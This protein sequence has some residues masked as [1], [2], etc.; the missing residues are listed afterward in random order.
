[1][2]KLKRTILFAALLLTFSGILS[3]EL[4]AQGPGF[5]EGVEDTPIDGGVTLIAATAVGYGIKKLRDK[6]RKF[7]DNND[8]T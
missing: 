5:D 2:N 8:V 7:D 3:T 1:M 6:K 4:L